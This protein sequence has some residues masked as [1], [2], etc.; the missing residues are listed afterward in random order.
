M[1]SIE[2]PVSSYTICSQ[3]LDGHEKLCIWHSEKHSLPVLRQ[4]CKQQGFKSYEE[5]ILWLIEHY[6]LRPFTWKFNHCNR[7][8]FWFGDR[9]QF[10]NRTGIVRRMEYR[11]ELSGGLEP[12][13]WWY[14]M[15]WDGRSSLENVHQ[16]SLQVTVLN[17]RR[18]I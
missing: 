17:P 14:G 9:L 18:K 2:Y 4:I 12:R 13:G 16:N 6:E 7:P 1:D 11:D 8:K 5:A 3:S 15:R 10:G